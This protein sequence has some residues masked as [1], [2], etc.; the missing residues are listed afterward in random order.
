M[1]GAR[2]GKHRASEA[3]VEVSSKAERLKALHNDGKLGT[4]PSFVKLDDASV[5]S[6]LVELGI[7]LGSDD[8]NANLVANELRL[9]VK[10]NEQL[11]E[12][13]DTRCEEFEVEEKVLAAEEE[14]DK[15]FLQNICSEIME[16]VMDFG[17]DDYVI[18]TR[19][20]TKNQKLR[21]REKGKRSKLL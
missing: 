3:D 12:R 14:I 9:S 7:S 19:N 17:G 13:E 20:I 21:K 18:P 1:A 4:F 15:L 6:N 8:S 10:T 11:V 5:I 2:R 16:E